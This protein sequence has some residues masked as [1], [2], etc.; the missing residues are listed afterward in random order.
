M[1]EAE[2]IGNV[3]TFLCSDLSKYMT[4]AQIEVTGGLD[5]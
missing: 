1:G 4:G 3:V 2:D 5:M